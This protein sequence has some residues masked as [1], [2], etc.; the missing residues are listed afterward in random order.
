MWKGAQA[1]RRPATVPKSTPA[2]LN[3]S[4]VESRQCYLSNFLCGPAL[5]VVRRFGA[6]LY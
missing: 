4:C 3:R 1:Q 5:E 6:H 2:R